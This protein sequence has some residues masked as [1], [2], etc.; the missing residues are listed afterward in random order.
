MTWGQDFLNRHVELLSKGDIDGLIREHYHDDAELV[1]FEFTR[2]GKDAI[3]S[4]LGVEE[5][6]QAGQVSNMEIIAQ[7]E[8]DD[9]IVFT[10]IV[11][12]KKMG[13]FVARDAMYVKDGKVLR[14]IA[15]TLPPDKDVKSEWV[16]A[17]ASSSQTRQVVNEY[18]RCVNEP[19]WDGWL[20]LFDD[21]AVVEDAL[22][23]R[24]E[25]KDALRASVKAIK[26]GFRSFRNLP[27][28]VV[29]EGDR[30][31]AVCRIEAVTAAGAAIESTGANFYRVPGG[32]ITEMSS[33]HDPAPF[34]RAFAPRTR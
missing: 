26:T 20:A 25:G 30:A 18:F 2:K 33:Y 9:T 14:H 22:S 17:T 5:P 11:T 32:R 15:L 12:S 24:M 13:R 28:E 29:V 34:S 1:T 6:A 10:A 31:M 7:A 3:A 23:P 16:T 19:D 27:L 4:Y 21:S 8:S